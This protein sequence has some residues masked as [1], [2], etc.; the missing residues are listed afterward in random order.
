M[1]EN[2]SFSKAV[3]WFHCRI[4]QPAAVIVTPLPHTTFSQFR[5][6]KQPVCSKREGPCIELH[7]F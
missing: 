3:N 5:S 4:M 2:E 7:P 1:V 6:T